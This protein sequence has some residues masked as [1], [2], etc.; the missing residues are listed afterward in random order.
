MKRVLLVSWYFYPASAVGAR[1]I[2][3]L[4]KSLQRNGHVVTVLTADSSCYSGIDPS[5][6]SP[7]TRE[8][9][10]RVAPRHYVRVPTRTT[11]ETVWQG[12]SR[13]TRF[14]LSRGLE[15]TL[16]PDLFAGWIK[17]AVER[18]DAI[19]RKQGIEAVISSGFPWSAFIVGDAIAQRYGLP[20]VM[21]YRDP[22]TASAPRETGSE[23]FQTRSQSIERA[24]L[25]RAAKIVA[26]TNETANL[27]R[28]TFGES[29]YA[30]L[31]VIRNGFD[32]DMH[33]HLRKRAKAAPVPADRRKLRMIH[34]GA[35]Y[36][37]RRLD[38]FI[39]AVRRLV[40]TGKITPH[41]FEFDSFGAFL[42]DDR[43]L[44][45]KYGVS[46]VFHEF[47][48]VPYEEALLTLTR[49]SMNLLVVGPAHAA[50]IPAKLYDYL[51]AER[52]IFA[53]GPTTS[54]VMEI[55]RRYDYGVCAAV[56]DSDDIATKLCDVLSR[57]S[58][59]EYDRQLCA[60]AEF[61]AGEQ[62][63]RL[64]RALSEC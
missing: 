43:R 28:K 58:A 59:G 25:E 27:F 33:Q 24:L 37:S 55:I 49:S 60:P 63:S 23:K 51:M 48:F 19:C 22:W 54:E 5:L 61:D 14:L 17:P 42:S 4:K 8:G 57:H 2:F 62:I 10:E 56:S 46:D 53:I 45:Q 21:D 35:Y 6:D 16:F 29:I 36:G 3:N 64:S 13:R 41:N 12:I 44:I 38:T 31:L 26:T 9:V 20:H 40:S 32:P 50:Q 47:D 30:K 39:D 18:A 34:T 11:R 7:V 1:R 15:R 52:P